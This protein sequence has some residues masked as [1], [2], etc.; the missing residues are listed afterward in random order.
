MSKKLGRSIRI[1]LLVITLVN[2]VVIA[3]IIGG[4]ASFSSNKLVRE[5][6]EQSLKNKTRQNG[7]IYETRIK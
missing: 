2:V 5:K 7:G 3:C 1:E 4:I 6:S